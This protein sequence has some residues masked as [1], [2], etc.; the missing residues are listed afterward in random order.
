MTHEAES[1]VNAIGVKEIN[2]C[3]WT[4]FVLFCVCCLNLFIACGPRE[5]WGCDRKKYLYGSEFS[6][7][8]VSAQATEERYQGF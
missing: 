6:I 3:C 4:I 7:T 1:E 8:S 2:G 5:V